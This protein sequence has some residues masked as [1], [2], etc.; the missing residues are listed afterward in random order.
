MTTVAFTQQLSTLQGEETHPMSP[1]FDRM[2]CV[3]ASQPV[4][5]AQFIAFDGTATHSTLVKVASSWHVTIPPPVY[6]LSQVTATVSLVVPS[7]A[8]ILAL[9]EWA[10]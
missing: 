2:R 9:F 6:P 3:L 7:T 5:I 8:P 10:T 1:G 4:K